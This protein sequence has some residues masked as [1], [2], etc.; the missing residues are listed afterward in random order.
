MA[1][2]CVSGWLVCCKGAHDSAWDPNHTVRSKVPLRSGGNMCEPVPPPTGAN[3]AHP[4]IQPQPLVPETDW[5][6]FVVVGFPRVFCKQAAHLIIIM[7][8]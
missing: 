1:G 4:S 7:S 2:S 5:T 3:G 8:H 6:I